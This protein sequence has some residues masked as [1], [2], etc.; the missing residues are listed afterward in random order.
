MEFTHLSWPPSLDPNLVT[1]T[2]GR[3][4]PSKF[5]SLCGTPITDDDEDVALLLWKDDG[6]G[7][8]FCSGCVERHWGMRA[9]P[10]EPETNLQAGVGEE[11]VKWRHPGH[12]PDCGG[13]DLSIGPRGGLAV[14][15]QCR[16]CG[17][18]WNTV[19]HKSTNLGLIERIRPAWQRQAGQ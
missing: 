5:C 12:C 8:R 13:N 1:W 17:Q 15:R 16:A 3:R 10:A 18:W 14:N 6:A 4:R 11:M 2:P 9:E 7:A 19:W